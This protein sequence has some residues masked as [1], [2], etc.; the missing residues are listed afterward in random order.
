VVECEGTCP[1]THFSEYIL[2]YLFHAFARYT[3]KNHL[4][5]SLLQLLG[6]S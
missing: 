2:N 3:V 6:F 1:I 4:I 5:D